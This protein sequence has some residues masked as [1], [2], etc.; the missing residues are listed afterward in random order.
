V[1][2]VDPT[3]EFIP[4][5][6][7]LGGAIFGGIVEIVTQWI[8]HEIDDCGN[9][10]EI[11]WKQVGWSAAVG[12]VGPGF[13]ESIG[14]IAYSAGAIKTLGTQATNT[15]NK[16]NKISNRIG[17][18]ARQIETQIL[19]QGGKFGINQGGKSVIDDNKCSCK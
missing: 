15:A 19:W 7:I 6:R 11:N 8:E 13:I 2:L 5:I 12:A 3:G 14:K 18:H 17:N 4:I 10:F 1:N 16:A 9:E